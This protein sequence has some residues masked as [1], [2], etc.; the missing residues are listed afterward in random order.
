MD[1]IDEAT[2]H[3]YLAEELRAKSELMGG[4]ATRLGMA[5]AYE[6]LAEDEER[7]SRMPGAEREKGLPH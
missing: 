7:A 2:R 5:Q 1:F 3:R 4:E 6:A